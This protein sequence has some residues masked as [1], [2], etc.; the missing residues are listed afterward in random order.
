MPYRLLDLPEPV[1]MYEYKEGYLN[2]YTDVGGTV[3]LYCKKC[4][5]VGGT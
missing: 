2:L 1:Q 5:K 3:L 4:T